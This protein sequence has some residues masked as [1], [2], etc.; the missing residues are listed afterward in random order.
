MRHWSQLATRNWRVRRSRTLGALLAIALGVGA[1]VWITCCYESVRQ[2]VL[3]WA[4]GYIGKAH[5]TVGSP[6]GRFDQIPERIVP[7]LAKLDNV[8]AVAPQLLQRLRCLPWPRALVESDMP[9]PA[10]WNDDTPEVDFVGVD[11]ATE[12]EVR[13]YPLRAGRQLRD[14]DGYA[15]TLEKAHADS[16]GLRLGD[17]LLLWRTTDET[18]VLIEIVGLFERRRLG[19]IQKPLA[20][21]RLPVLQELTGRFAMLTSADV[22]LKQVDER[23]VARA[24]ERI[25]L[26]VR[27]IDRNATVRSAEARIR[28]IE[29]AQRQQY[30]LLVLLS[31]VAMLTALFI[32]LSTLSMG[33]IERVG[34]LGLMR[35]VGLTG[36]Q[37]AWL[38]LVEVLPLGVLGILLGVPI[39]FGLTALTVWLVPEYVGRFV[40]SFSGVA[41]AAAAGLITT[42]VAALVPAVAA[43]GVSPMEAARP[44]ARRAGNLVLLAVALLALA[45]L[46][47]Q[48]YGVLANVH[49][50]L[51]F[52]QWAAGAVV[53]L[54]VAYALFAPLAVRLIGSPAVVAAAALLRV[55]SRLL[56]DQVGHA[57]WRSAGVCC[58]LMVGLSLIVG[59]L[60]VNESVT[61]GWQFPSQFPEAYVWSF[62]QLAP[63]ADEVLQTIPGIKSFTVA[64]S[65]NVIVEERPAF[66]EELLRSITWFM[67]CDPDS[68]MDLVRL[69]FLEGSE[70]QAR[71]LLKQGGY[72]VIADDFSRSRNK[73][74]GDL[75]KVFWGTTLVQVQ[76]FKVAA[77]V[78]SPALDIAAGYFQA[79]THYN[80]VAAGSVMGTN[81]DLKRLF[82]IDGTK[83]V[84]LNFDLLPEPPPPGWPPPRGSPQAATLAAAYY[85]A[86]LPLERRWQRWRE[87]QVLRAVKRGLNAPQAFYGTVRELKDE[88]DA[89]LTGMMRLLTAVPAVALLVAA[90]GVA[91]LMT[92]NVAARARQLAILRAVGAT[93]GLVLR[94]VV[95]EALVLGLLGSGLGLALGLHLATNVTALLDRMWGFR[96]SLELPWTYL[97]G[98]I[99]L[100]VTLCVLAGVIPARHASRAN[101][102]DALHIP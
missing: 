52:L 58:G 62:Q 61:R 72:V 64:N 82:G 81:E 31:C 2:T 65:I 16:E 99:A 85:D 96:V 87:E 89:K 18:P 26:A 15:C 45:A 80:V 48:H 27:R 34:Q 3:A 38:M 10:G 4:G 17:Y 98:A 21:I 25:R 97:G 94:M 100:T 44:R 102:V 84:L 74:V 40:V 30:F 19:E 59:I 20:L 76:T 67:G 39:G 33:M 14:D 95:G 51:Q 36:G 69:E 91:N 56:Q 60:V 68:F 63:G 92:A 49:R 32:I 5:V 101:I 66:A 7:V 11:L 37:V 24:F 8:Q 29:L 53:L 23:G 9:K 42:I 83:L 35:C 54:Y 75:V 13:E 71:R 86:A 78:R 50:S 57:V 46:A 70:P 41:L 22:V 73:H 90:I 55:R 6:W 12:F 77:V 88:I 47:A 79:H 28:Q 93:R 43:V 1:V